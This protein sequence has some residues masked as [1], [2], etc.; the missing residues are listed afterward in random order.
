MERFKNPLP[1]PPTFPYNM[2]L[3]ITQELPPKPETQWKLIQCC[4]FFFAKHPVIPI[5]D[6]N[7]CYDEEKTIVLQLDDD[8]IKLEVPFAHLGYKFWFTGNL[9]YDSLEVGSIQILSS[10]LPLIFKWDCINL[11]VDSMS[12]TYDELKL[13]L[14]SKYLENICLEKVNIIHSNGSKVTAEEVLA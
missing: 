14:S 3:N 1:L 6:I 9:F 2:M 5:S 8:D 7:E 11:M 13:I 10:T 4:K 12:F